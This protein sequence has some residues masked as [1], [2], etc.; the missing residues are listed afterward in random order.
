MGDYNPFNNHY[1]G[2]LFYHSRINKRNN[3]STS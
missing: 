2:I 3:N 1:K